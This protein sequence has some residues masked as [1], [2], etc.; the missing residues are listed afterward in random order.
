[1]SSNKIGAL[2]EVLHAT[3]VMA[4][5]YFPDQMLV[6]NNWLTAYGMLQVH[7]VVLTRRQT[8]ASLLVIDIVRMVMT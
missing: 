4:V 1:M 6:C 2:V 7:N 3:F 8:N 5:F